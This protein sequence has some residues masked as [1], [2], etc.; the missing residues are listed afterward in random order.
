M[1]MSR[2][3]ESTPLYEVLHF[4]IFQCLHSSTCIMRLLFPVAQRTPLGRFW[5][6]TVRSLSIP[7]N[8][9][10]DR[11]G[12]AAIAS[13]TAPLLERR[14]TKNLAGALAHPRTPYRR[15]VTSRRE[16][17]K[18][19]VLLLCAFPATVPFLS[20]LVSRIVEQRRDNICAANFPSFF[21]C[22]FEMRTLLFV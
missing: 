4:R 14:P 19:L 10:Y 11:S 16:A 12:D 1:S 18:I 17:K 22:L 3:V 13:P 20:Y 2:A 9:P 15:T 5:Q 7:V 6:R 8:P 21:S